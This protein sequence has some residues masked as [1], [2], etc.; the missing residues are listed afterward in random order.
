MTQHVLG[1]LLRAVGVD[2]TRDVTVQAA[3][4]RGHRN[5]LVR[6]LPQLEAE[7]Q[8]TGSKVDLPPCSRCTVLSWKR[9]EDLGAP[10]HL[11]VWPLTSSKDLP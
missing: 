2:G 7:A 9:P 5:G 4:C 8:R 11:G 10:G 3:E 6:P 1:Q